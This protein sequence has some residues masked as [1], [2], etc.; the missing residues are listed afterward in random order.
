[1]I[2]SHGEGWNLSVVR[3]GRLVRRSGLV[4]WGR[5]VDRLRGVFGGRFVRRFMVIVFGFSTVRNISNVATVSINRV[6]HSLDTAIRQQN[7]VRSAGGITISG[8]ILTKVKSSIV[9]LDG[10]VVVV[11]GVSVFVLGFMIGWGGIVGRGWVVGWGWL[12]NGSGLVR[13][14]SHGSGS[15]A[16]SKKGLELYFQNQKLNRDVWDILELV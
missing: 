1:M 14:L 7:M 15:Q 9:I 10:I 3:W 6:F 13:S 8:F 11:S 5:L 2:Q 12:V 4:R 16:K